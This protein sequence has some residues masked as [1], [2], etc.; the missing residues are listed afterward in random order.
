MGTL[1]KRNYV[2][3]SGKGK[4]SVLKATDLGIE[5]S[6]FLK[7]SFDK[8]VSMKFTAQ[9]ENDLDSISNGN[10]NW[11]KILDKYYPEMKKEAIAVKSEQEKS[12]EKCP[13]CGR[14]LVQ[15][16]GKNGKFVG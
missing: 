7:K 3:R 4:G 2:E 15:K 14:D 9:M 16:V 5:V 10:V 13:D 11:V 6:D 1:V 12:G 8:Y